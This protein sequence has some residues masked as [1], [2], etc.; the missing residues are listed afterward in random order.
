MFQDGGRAFVS[1]NWPKN[2]EENLITACLS[3]QRQTQQ[4]FASS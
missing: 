2:V 1:Q 3:R 4:L